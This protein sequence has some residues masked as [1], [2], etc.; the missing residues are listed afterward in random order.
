MYRLSVLF[1]YSFSLKYNKHPS[2]TVI[3]SQIKKP[4]SSTVLFRLCTF[5]NMNAVLFPLKMCGC[6]LRAAK[7]CPFYKCMY[8]I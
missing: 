8:K 7:I 2:N 4:I 1:S 3:L 5:P 6:E